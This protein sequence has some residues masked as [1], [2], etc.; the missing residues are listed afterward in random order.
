MWFTQLRAMLSDSFFDDGINQRSKAD[1]SRADSEFGLDIGGD[2]PGERGAFIGRAEGPASALERAMADWCAADVEAD[3]RL[4]AFAGG[5]RLRRLAQQQRGQVAD[6]ER[7]FGPRWMRQGA[8]ADNQRERRQPQHYR[9]IDSRHSGEEENDDAGRR[10]RKTQQARTAL[11]GCIA[12]HFLDA[13]DEPDEDVQRR[14]GLQTPRIVLQGRS[15]R[16]IDDDDDNVE[17]QSF[18]DRRAYRRPSRVAYGAGLE[19][20]RR[21]AETSATRAFDGLRRRRGSQADAV[22][23]T[24]VLP[25]PVP[26]NFL[27]PVDLGLPSRSGARATT[28]TIVRPRKERFGSSTS[29]AERSA[30]FGSGMAAGREAAMSRRERFASLGQ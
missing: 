23:P 22:T 30:R 11:P 19:A 9:A 20:I 17:E 6:G 25:A 28:V 7:S 1:V 13:D 26:A 4:P 14:P 24:S 15:A 8:G 27:P 16:R 21:V 12:T 10:T 3:G 29:S 5:G 2:A 18:P